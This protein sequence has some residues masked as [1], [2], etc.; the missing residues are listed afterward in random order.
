VGLV[1]AVDSQIKGRENVS[2]RREPSKSRALADLN[3][4]LVT[5]WC[6]L[7]LRIDVLNDLGQWAE[8][9]ENDCFIYL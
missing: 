6:Y 5:F 2:M 8:E 4:V 7:D 1:Q 3:G 9:F